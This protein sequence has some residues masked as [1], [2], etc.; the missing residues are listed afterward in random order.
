MHSRTEVLGVEAADVN[1]RCAFVI[2]VG[3]LV[4]GVVRSAWGWQLRQ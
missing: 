4:E 3:G 1:A 2:A